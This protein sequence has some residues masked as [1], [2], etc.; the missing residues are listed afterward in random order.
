MPVKCL[1]LRLRLNN[2]V[3]RGQ[4]ADVLVPSQTQGVVT[5]AVDSLRRSSPP[6]RQ[7]ILEL[8]GAVVEAERESGSTSV[9]DPCPEGVSE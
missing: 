9:Y 4:G 6:V 3:N 8:P 1:R 2:S 7:S 5:R